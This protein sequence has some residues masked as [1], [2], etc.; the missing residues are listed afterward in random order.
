MG[1]EYQNNTTFDFNNDYN[2]KRKNKS[3]LNY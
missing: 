3:N 1:E 2:N